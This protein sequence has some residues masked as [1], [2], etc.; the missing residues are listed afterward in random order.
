MQDKELVVSV[1]DVFEESKGE[2]SLDFLLAFQSNQKALE[3]F[4]GLQERL[5]ESNVM[6]YNHLFDVSMNLYENGMKSIDVQ[7]DAINNSHERND[8]R[9]LRDGF[10]MFIRGENE[11]L[12][13][14]IFEQFI[15]IIRDEI[16]EAQQ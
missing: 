15:A 5:F 8:Q 12:D 13:E 10:E 2:M 9:H 7:V 4:S 11:S 6:T 14:L 1:V 16:E 3:I